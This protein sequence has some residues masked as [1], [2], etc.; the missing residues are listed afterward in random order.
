[1][2]TPVSPTPTSPVP[3]PI[4][5]VKKDV[6]VLLIL[7]ALIGWVLSGFLGYSWKQTKDDLTKEQS[8]HS[9]AVTITTPMYVG[10]KIVYKTETQVV[11]DQG[12]TVI[13]DKTTT[14]IKSGCALGL[15][16]SSRGSVGA[17]L[18]PDVFGIGPGSIQ[19]LALGS[20]D[21]LVGGV[22]YCLRF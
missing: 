19:V 21:E 11:H 9:A 22:G 8:S 1:M 7:L 6:P 2:E 14:T 5:E 16:Y 4:Q 15:C 10:G 3:D 18:A 13:H 12:T 20:K 17:Y